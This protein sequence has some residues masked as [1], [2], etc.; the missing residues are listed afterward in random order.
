MRESVPRVDVWYTS[1]L[2]M[3][4]YSQTAIKMQCRDAKANDSGGGYPVARFSGDG[5]W[6]FLQIALALA[7]LATIANG[8]PAHARNRTTPVSTS[9]T[10]AVATELVDVVAAYIAAGEQNDPAARGKYLGPKVFYYGHARTHQQA[11]KEITTLYRRWPQR[12]FALTES[13]D[14]FEIPNHHGVYRVTAVYEYKFDNQNEHLS[15]K[16]KLTCVVEHDQQGTRITGIDEK[17]VS[18]STV[19]Q[20]G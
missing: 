18:G 20:G 4:F 7:S 15:G 8:E 11:V 14:L 17:L 13:I 9:A 5:S 3:S 2:P 1:T 6:R 12:K 10:P 16:S 19:Y